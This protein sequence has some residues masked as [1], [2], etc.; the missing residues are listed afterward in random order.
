MA[1][2]TNTKNIIIGCTG[3]VATIKIPKLSLLLKS[4]GY[5]IIIVPTNS[6]L[7]FLKSA[8]LSEKRLPSTSQYQPCCS[9]LSSTRVEPCLECMVRSLYPELNFEMDKGEWT[10]WN[11]RGDPVKHIELRN[12]ADVLLIAPLSANSLAS[13]AQ[14][15]CNNLLLCI[16]RAWDMKK[17]FIFCPAMNTHM[18]NHPFTKIHIDILKVCSLVIGKVFFIATFF[19][20]G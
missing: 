11:N 6:A 17:H 12:W 13:I 9:D 3:S 8:A 20:K 15:L 10:S 14:G 5:S 18:Y 7:H 1:E 4:K 16:V 19:Q 2:G